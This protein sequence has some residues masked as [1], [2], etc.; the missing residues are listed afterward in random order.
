MESSTAPS[1]DGLQPLFYKQFRTKVG[2][3][4][5]DA[6]LSMLNSSTIPNNLNHTHLT[7]I[8]KV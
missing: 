2:V 3:E 7:L 6:V 5:T 4:V 1:P 8:P